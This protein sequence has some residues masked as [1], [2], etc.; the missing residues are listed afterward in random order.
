VAVEFDPGKSSANKVKHGIDFNA[1]QELWSGKT[2]SVTIPFPVE[3]RRLVIGKIAGKHWAAIVTA[4]G[5]NIRLISVRRARKKEI[6][7][8][9]KTN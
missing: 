8:Y 3:I 5:D 1:A 2:V 7:E 4:R 6:Q 9:E